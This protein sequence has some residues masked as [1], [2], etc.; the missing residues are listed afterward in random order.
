M[1][2]SSLLR[3]ALTALTS[4][5]AIVGG[6]FL[7]QNNPAS[8]NKDKHKFLY[9]WGSNCFGQLGLGGE[10]NQISPQLIEHLEHQS[11]TS[12]FARDNN[13]ATIVNNKVWTFGSG[14]HGILGH[15]NS[16]DQPNQSAPRVVKLNKDATSVAVG[17]FHMLALT[18]GGKV[19]SWGRNNAGQLGFEMSGSH[20][21]P[22][23]V[24]IKEDVIALAAGRQH[25]LAL[26]KQGQ[27][28]SFGNGRD[29]QLGNGDKTTRKTPTLINELKDVISIAC[30]RDSSFALTKEGKL[31]SW[32]RDDYGQLAQGRSQRFTTRPRL[33]ESLNNEK[34]ASIAF[35]EYHGVAVTDDGR[36]FSWGKNA[37]GQC[38][39]GTT[40][41]VSQPIQIEALEGIV[42]KSAACGNA[43]TA[44][45]TVD[46]EL[47]KWGSGRSGELGRGSAVESNAAY[48]ATPL[49]VKFVGDQKV[50]QIALGNEHCVAIV[51]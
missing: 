35:G 47:W 11:A 49:K 13:S 28:Y 23:A 24:D 7:V 27:V 50:V 19:F 25:S 37:S 48:R 38:G 21:E 45:I 32:G 1:F 51:E 41:N 15:G 33:V 34:I 43:H 22:Q 18:A 36:I 6:V 5:T 20:G 42:I 3:P 31:Y 44:A 10:K 12:V 46:N 14:A 39:N 30:G 2:R 40:N 9:S 29:G 8:C 4:A 17:T 16:M 26:T